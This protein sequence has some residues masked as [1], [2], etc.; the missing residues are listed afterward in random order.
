MSAAGIEAGAETGSAPGIAAAAGIPVAAGIEAEAD[1]EAEPSLVCHFEL[2]D[3][4]GQP[5]QTPV[6]HSRPWFHISR[7]IWRLLQVHCPQ[8]MQNFVLF[9]LGYGPSQNVRSDQRNRGFHAL[10]MAI[11]FLHL[12]TP[13]FIADGGVHLL[14]GHGDCR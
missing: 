5:A 12:R 8:C 14:R 10:S 13:P 11:L 7:R 9:P 1:N 6:R 2:P 3:R 4:S